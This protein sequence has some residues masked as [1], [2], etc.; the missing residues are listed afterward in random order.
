MDFWLVEHLHI[1]SARPT[2]MFFNVFAFHSTHLQPLLVQI[3]PDIFC[4]KT[5]YSIGLGWAWDKIR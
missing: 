3:E 2:L 1:G 5:I 4:T